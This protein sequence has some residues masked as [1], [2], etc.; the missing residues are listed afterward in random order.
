M[1]N[2][3]AHLLRGEPLI[4]DGEAGLRQVEL[5]NAIQLSGWTGERIPIPCGCA[6]YDAAPQ[7]RINEE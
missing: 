7:K 3:A 1:E 6:R 2:F 4:A 5:A